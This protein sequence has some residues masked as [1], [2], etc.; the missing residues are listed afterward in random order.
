VDAL[1]ARLSDNAIGVR[2]AAVEALAAIGGA[3]A[4]QR[5]Q[6]AQAT[7]THPQVKQALETALA[8]PKQ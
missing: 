7:E 1:A 4:R 8:R 2:V 5:L 3:K 6:A